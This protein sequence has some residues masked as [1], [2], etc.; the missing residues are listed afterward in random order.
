MLNLQGPLETSDWEL[1]RLKFTGRDLLQSAGLTAL[2]N[3][4]RVRGRYCLLPIA[5]PI[6][7]YSNVAFK[8][9]MIQQGW[10]PG[11]WGSTINDIWGGRG[12]TI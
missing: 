2:F 11:V 8:I 4:K 9:L 12:G 5:S 3:G 10:P 1:I 7:F 6:A